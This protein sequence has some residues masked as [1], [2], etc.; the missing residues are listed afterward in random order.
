[1]DYVGAGGQVWCMVLMNPGFQQGY[2]RLG[3]YHHL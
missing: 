1:M 2:Y 3:A